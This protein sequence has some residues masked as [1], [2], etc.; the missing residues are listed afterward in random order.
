MILNTETLTVK[1]GRMTETNS[2]VQVGRNSSLTYGY[3]MLSSLQKN[4]RLNGGVM[5]AK[6]AFTTITT[7]KHP[8]STTIENFLDNI[9]MISPSGPTLKIRDLKSYVVWRTDG[10]DVSR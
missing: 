8:K 5:S 6:K 3:L 4:P 2:R 7:R 10:R 1:T 9:G